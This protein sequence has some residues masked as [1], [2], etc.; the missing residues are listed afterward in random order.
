MKKIFLLLIFISSLF[1]FQ[2]WDSYTK[3]KVVIDRD[4]YKVY[5]DEKYKEPFITYYVLEYK[6]VRKRTRK[7]CKFHY[8]PV[9]DEKYQYNPNFYLGK[10]FDRGHSANKASL[11]DTYYHKCLT[12]EMINIVPQTHYF[13]AYIW[14]LTEKFERI[15]VK[16][17]KKVYV[18]NI[19]IQDG[20][21]IKG[22]Y[23]PKYQIKLIYVP[24]K[25]RFYGFIFDRKYQFIKINPLEAFYLAKFDGHY[26]EAFLYRY[27]IRFYI[28]AN[29]PVLYYRGK[30]IFK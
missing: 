18:F 20:K 30:N 10:G 7:D 1:S 21:K 24:K 19:F 8:S 6:N 12:Y 27:G 22:L 15:L 26:R 2:L 9:I 3:N 23:I 28:R 13:N 14:G 5:Y 17:Y 25:K 11:D 4:V 16:E 29:K